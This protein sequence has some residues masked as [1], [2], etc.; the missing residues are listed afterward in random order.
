MYN[1]GIEYIVFSSG[2]YI[3]A[4]PTEGFTG[5]TAYAKLKASGVSTRKFEYVLCQ[6]TIALETMF[7]V[8]VQDETYLL[9]EDRSQPMYRYNVLI[10]TLDMM[11]KPY[12]AYLLKE[13]TV[14]QPVK[15]A[16]SAHINP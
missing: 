12:A 5:G 9:E 14:Q 16:V 6:D 13:D 1:S 8:H 10:G 11:E 15:S 2:D 4:I 7:S 3:T